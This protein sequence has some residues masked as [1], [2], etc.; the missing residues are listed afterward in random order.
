MFLSSGRHH[1]KQSLA[2][3][4]PRVCIA[5]EKEPAEKKE[6]V[7]DAVDVSC[8]YDTSVMVKS[9]KVHTRHT[10]RNDVDI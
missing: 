8:G 6:V 4:S 3:V 2:Y 7:A 10:P 9:A 1:A 5:G